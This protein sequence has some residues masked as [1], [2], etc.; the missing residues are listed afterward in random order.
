MGA[1]GPAYRCGEAFGGLTWDDVEVVEV[2]SYGAALRA[3]VDGQ[4]DVAGTTP[5]ASARY[6]LEGTS[7]GLGWVP[8]REDNAEGW[9]AVRDVASFF[10][11]TTAKAG[12]G[13]T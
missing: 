7:R 12:A 2:A 11:P 10:A 13:I 5:T 6:E 3:L 1:A 9:Q 4:A 8:L